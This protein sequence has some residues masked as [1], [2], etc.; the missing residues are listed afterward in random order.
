MFNLNSGFFPVTIIA[1]I[2][3][4]LKFQFF[5]TYDILYTQRF[6]LSIHLSCCIYDD[7][8][9][10]L[11]LFYTL[12]FLSGHLSEIMSAI[13]SILSTIT[14]CKYLGEWLDILPTISACTSSHL[15]MHL[16]SFIHFHQF[17]LPWLYQIQ[18]T[19]PSADII[20]S[21]PLCSVRWYD[22]TM[23]RWYDGTMVC[24]Y[25]I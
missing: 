8:E 25:L 12:H 1:I 18:S 15:L 23:V 9:S 14:S 6:W 2:V 21:N 11:S 10:I 16:V 17:R 20:T 22:G 4:L 19:K 24:G 5:S 7:S 3:R 13:C